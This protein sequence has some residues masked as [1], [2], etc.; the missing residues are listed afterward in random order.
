MNQAPVCFL[1]LDSINV[2][3]YFSMYERLLQG[4][5]DLIYWDRSENDEQTA[6]ANVYRYSHPVR[7]NSKALNFKDL[8]TGYLGFRL[9]AKKILCNNN[10]KLVIALTGNVAV[11]L[12]S[13]LKRKYKE[14]YIMD[15]RDYFLEDILLYKKI[16][17]S[18]IDSAALALISSPSFVSFLGD[19]DFKVIHNVQSIE[20]ADVNAIRKRQHGCKPFI[21]ANI[22]TA[23]TLDLDIETIKYFAN[24]KRFELRYIGR[25]F[26]VLNRFCEEN[27]I[28][29]VKASGDFPSAQTIEF[30]RDLDGIL[31]L[32]G[33]ERTNFI[34]CLPNKLY[35]AAQLRLPIFV[36]PK[37][38]MS[39]V[40]KEYSLGLSLDLKD[41][42]I[43]EMILNS[44]APNIQ[45]AR[46]LGADR[47]MTM[48]E[49]Q[50]KEAY[51]AI[52]KVLSDFV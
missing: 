21:L 23:K 43:K 27:N 20:P 14:K 49:T 13:V 24:D 45:E 25:G 9:F 5:Y 4:K 40:V 51:V 52:S 32:F 19:H 6:A 35:Y 50:N 1:N 37:T 39:K 41:Y 47:F 31:S 28:W 16:E 44:Y 30:Y 15:I 8:L 34:H 7:K 26:E 46:K 11:L 36:T 17:Q 10:Y 12:G 42:S 18:V 3:P 2:T 38:Y 22:G 29:N 33:N 48:V